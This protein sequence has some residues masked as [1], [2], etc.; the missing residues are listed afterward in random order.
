M[1]AGPLHNLT[2]KL[3]RRNDRDAPAQAQ[4]EHK[5]VWMHGF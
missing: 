5:L 3:V 1:D 2:L 4:P